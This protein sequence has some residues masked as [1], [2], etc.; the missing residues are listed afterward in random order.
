M[1][2]VWS[3]ENNMDPMCVLEELS[4]MSEAAQMLIARLAPTAHVHML[5]N[6]CI[7]SKGHCTAFPQAVQEPPTILPLLPAEVDIIRVKRQ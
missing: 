1:P 4:G 5:K 7:T 6:G 2:K 3:D